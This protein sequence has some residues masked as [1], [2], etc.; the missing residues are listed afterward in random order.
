MRLN[1]VL[2]A[3][4][5]AAKPLK[6]EAGPVG[7]RLHRAQRCWGL[8]LPTIAPLVFLLSGEVLGSFG[9]RSE[10]SAVSTIRHRR[11]SRRGSCQASLLRRRGRTPAEINLVAH[12][13]LRRIQILNLAQ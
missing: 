4:E 5:A 12:H 2:K 3:W 10:D 1:G 9:S 6:T 7:G 11:H 13:W 8:A